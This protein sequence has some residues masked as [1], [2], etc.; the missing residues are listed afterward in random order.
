[1]LVY[2]SVSAGSGFVRCFLWCEVVYKLEMMLTALDFCLRKYKVSINM[3][4]KDVHIDVH[5]S[6][7]WLGILGVY[8]SNL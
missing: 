6:Y 3:L 7:A 1:M 2:W 5:S 8:I 4:K